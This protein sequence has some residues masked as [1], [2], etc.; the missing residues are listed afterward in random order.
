MGK[1]E[2][3]PRNKDDNQQLNPHMTPGPGIELGSHWKEKS[4]FTTAHAPPLL[5]KIDNF[6]V[7]VRKPTSFRLGIVCRPS[8]C[9]LIIFR[10]LF[11]KYSLLLGSLCS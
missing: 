5:I 7:S 2:N 8:Y 6:K 3:N 11:Y 10:V 4:A 1:P 9:V